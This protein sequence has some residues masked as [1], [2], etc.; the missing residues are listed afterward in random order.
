MF[1]YHS[2]A[3]ASDIRLYQLVPETRSPNRVERFFEVDKCAEQ[4]LFFVGRE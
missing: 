1:V 4:F 2:K 3:F